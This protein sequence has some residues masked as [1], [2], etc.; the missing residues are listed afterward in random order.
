MYR[1]GHCSC[2]LMATKMQ[3]FGCESSRSSCCHRGLC[4]VSS[5]SL[6]VL[7]S[8]TTSHE[9][10]VHHFVW[11]I[12]FYYTLLYAPLLLTLKH[13]YYCLLIWCLDMIFP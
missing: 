1:L 2:S 4:S 10:Q 12:K 11:L 7:S 13:L 5:V 8:W 6:N 9:T 3:N